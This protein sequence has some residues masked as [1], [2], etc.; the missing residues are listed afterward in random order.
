MPKNGYTRYLRSKHWKR[1]KKAKYK[2]AK[3][4]KCEI[5]GLV[6]KKNL[7]VHHV[8]YRQLFNVGLKDLRLVCISCHE[9]IHDLLGWFFVYESDNSA[10]RWAQTLAAIKDL[11]GYIESYKELEERYQFLIS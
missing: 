7:H 10:D 4:W 5:C 1:L 8:N 2:R 6:G 9:K 11:P 3:I